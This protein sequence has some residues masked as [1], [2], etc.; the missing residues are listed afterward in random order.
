MNIVF[1]TDVIIDVLKRKEQTAYQIEDISTQDDALFCSV[2]SISEILAGMRKNEEKDTW[3]LL[4]ALDK[5]NVDENIAELAGK[6]KGETKSHQLMLDDCLIAATAML[7]N[8]VLFTK[9]VKHYP[10]KNLKLQAIK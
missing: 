7:N 4:D 9:N 5:F 3:E 10:F 1:D 8:A 2:I 6:L